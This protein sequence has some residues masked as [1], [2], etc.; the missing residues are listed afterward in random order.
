MDITLF[1]INTMFVLYLV[2]F[3]LGLVLFDPLHY[4]WTGKYR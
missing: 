1:V 2:L 4:R 3:L